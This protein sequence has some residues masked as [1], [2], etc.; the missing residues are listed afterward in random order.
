VEKLH[1][2]FRDAWGGR[3]PFARNRWK[4]Q[5]AREEA[6]AGDKAAEAA[7]GKK[8]LDMLWRFA[9]TADL[10]AHPLTAEQFH[11]IWLT[12]NVTLGGK[13]DR[14]DR[15]EDGAL[16]VLD[17]KTGKPPRFRGTTGGA[18]SAGA[19]AAGDAVRRTSRPLGEDD[20]QLAAYAL[21]VTRKFRG[22]VARCT[23]V[24][25]NDD[26]DLWFEPTDEQLR[27]KE[28]EIV[29]ICDRILAD[30]GKQEFRPTPNALCPW[31][32][33]RSL[34]PEGEEWV[35]SHAAP[36]VPQEDVPF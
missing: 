21:L 6:F 24:Y 13:I 33:Y 9:Q 20:L 19:P 32:E 31:C 2:L 16:E 8:G 28:A 22:R 3:G 36:D 29:T 14:I 12:E 34:C 4:Q 1:E 25:L 26:L 11:E 15:R 17:Y 27:E 23:Y 5:Q 30:Q 7:W 18:A 35:K 10:A